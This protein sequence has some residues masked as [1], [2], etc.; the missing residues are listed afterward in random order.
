[1]EV[2]LNSDFTEFVNAAGETLHAER[3]ERFVP[4]AQIEHSPRF[5]DF[6]K[7][8]PRYGK[9][10]ACP[11]NTPDFASY[12]GDAGAARII[13]F[14]IPLAD[15][16]KTTADQQRTDIRQ[17]GKLLADELATYQKQGL[18]VAGAGG[19]RACE[20]CAGESGGDT[21][22]QPAERIFSLEAMGVDVSS[23]L[24]RNFGF[25][26]EWNRDGQRANYLCTVGAVFYD[27][28]QNN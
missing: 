15:P 28:C 14:R 10:L 1:V 3:H 8:C 25:S 7:T 24:K 12:A 11:P 18:K 13:C 22:H 23:L 9:N 27:D 2:L 6:C 20:T 21:C 26:L 17:A 19:C 4:V 16:D 5:Q